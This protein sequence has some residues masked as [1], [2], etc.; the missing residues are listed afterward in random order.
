MTRPYAPKEGLEVV[1][2]MTHRAVYLP[3]EV[4]GG[5]LPDDGLGAY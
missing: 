4:G 1:R 3:N 2:G 5:P